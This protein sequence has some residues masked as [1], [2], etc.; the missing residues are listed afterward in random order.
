MG[1]PLNILPPL[2]LTPPKPSPSKENDPALVQELTSTHASLA[3]LRRTHNTTLVQLR[4]AEDSVRTLN[5]QKQKLQT[6]LRSLADRLLQAATAP[7]GAPPP[8]L[9]DDVNDL[10][11]AMTAEQIA[12][13]VAETGIPLSYNEMKHSLADARHEADSARAEAIASQTALVDRDSTI[14][15]LSDQLASMQADLDAAVASSMRVP[16][17]E[18][19]QVHLALVASHEALKDKHA[20]A[21][22]QGKAALAGATSDIDQLSSALH[23][24]KRETAAMEARAL[25]AEE[26]AADAEA[27]VADLRAQLASLQEASESKLDSCHA[28]RL[29]LKAQAEQASD[30]AASRYR[31]LE[32]TY[33]ALVNAHEALKSRYDLLREQMGPLA[34][35]SD[36]H[37]ALQVEYAALKATTAAAMDRIQDL[38]S[39]TQASES[40][41]A[42]YTELA[43]E[44]A[45]VQ[46]VTERA[47]DSI[48]VLQADSERLA[49]LYAAEQERSALAEAQV[50]ALR[51]ELAAAQ[52]GASTA[53]LA[54]A[55]QLVSA[56]Q[57]AS[58]AA[59]RADMA[60]AELHDA[61][62]MLQSMEDE[63]ASLRDDIAELQAELASERASHS[64][65]RT[66]SASLESQLGGAQDALAREERAHADTK[67]VLDRERASRAADKEV[68]AADMGVASVEVTRWREAEVALNAQLKESKISL[69]AARADA[70]SSKGAVAEL[71]ATLSLYESRLEG[72][73]ASEAAL[74]A[75]LHEAQT[76]LRVLRSQVQDSTSAKS[77]L[78]RT[79]EVAQTSLS[80][81]E[82]QIATLTTR[83]NGALET[84]AALEAQIIKLSSSETGWK[85]Q[86]DN[87]E[88]SLR[89]LRSTLASLTS[90]VEE[91]SH[92][93]ELSQLEASQ[94]RNANAHFKDDVAALTTKV[95]ELDHDRQRAEQNILALQMTVKQHVD[96]LAVSE[97]NAGETANALANAKLELGERNSRITQ[98]VQLFKREGY[99][100]AETI[101][102]SDGSSSIRNIVY[103]VESSLESRAKDTQIHLLQ[104]AVADAE[105]RIAD[106]EAQVEDERRN[107]ARAASSAATERDA[108]LAEARHR[109]EDAIAESRE[110]TR[111]K[112]MA[113]Q[114]RLDR[115][116]SAHRE[117]MVTMEERLV[118][119]AEEAS[120]KL[121]AE[122]DAQRTKFTSRLASEA[123]KASARL[124]SVKQ[125][126]ERDLQ[127]ASAK[128][129]S[130]HDTL[131]TEHERAIAD[132]KSRAAD[133]VREAE[134]RVR[135][136]LEHELKSVSADLAHTRTELASIQSHHELQMTTKL[137]ELRSSYEKAAMEAEL[138]AKS[139]IAQL[140]AAASKIRAE[141]E[142]LEGLRSKLEILSSEKV[143]L[144]RACGDLQHENKRIA[145]LYHDKIQDLS[146]R[147]ADL[148]SELEAASEA[149]QELTMA[150]ADARA[151]AD[152]GAVAQAALQDTNARLSAEL[153]SVKSILDA[154]DKEHAATL[155]TLTSAKK[156]IRRLKKANEASAAL[157]ADFEA[158]VKTNA[159]LEEALTKSRA[160]EA[161]TSASLADAQ[162][163]ISALQAGAAVF[164]DERTSL[165]LAIKALEHQAKLDAASA[166][167]A[168]ELSAREIASLKSTL[169][170]ERDRADRLQT[171]LTKAERDISELRHNAK[172]TSIEIS[173]LRQELMEAQSK[174]ARA[175]DTME[176]AKE[177]HYTLLA[178]VEQASHLEAQVSRLRGALEAARSENASLQ[179]NMSLIDDA[180]AQ[181]EA[182]LAAEAEHSASMARA[183]DE[184]CGALRASE[185]QYAELQ[186][187][188]DGLIEGRITELEEVTAERD[189]LAS[190]VAHLEEANAV[191]LAR[192][193]ALDAARKGMSSDQM[194]VLSQLEEMALKYEAAK[195]KG[196]ALS[197]TVEKLEIQNE[198]DGR[199][200][201]QLM[202]Q[203]AELTQRIESESAAR[204][205]ADAQV[206]SQRSKLELLGSVTNEA[207]IE[208]C[209]LRT[210]HASAT[211]QV[212][213][214]QARV[215]Q[216]EEDVRQAKAEAELAK[217][218]GGAGV[219]PESV[220]LARALA[221]AADDAVAQAREQ[222]SSASTGPT[223][224]ATT[225][226]TRTGGDGSCALQE[227]ENERLRSAL[228]SSQA[229]ATRLREENR[230]YLASYS[231]LE[232]SLEGLNAQL[233]TM[234]HHHGSAP[235]TDDGA[236]V[237]EQA[238]QLEVSALQKQNA[239]LRSTNEWLESA[240]AQLESSLLSP[241]ATG[242]SPSSPVRKPSPVSRSGGGGSIGMDAHTK[243]LYAQMNALAQE[244]MGLEAKLAMVRGELAKTEQDL[245][246]ARSTLAQVPPGFAQRDPDLSIPKMVQAKAELESQVERSRVRIEALEAELASSRSECRAVEIEL[247]TVRRA[248][249]AASAEASEARRASA[250]NT[251]TP[252]QLDAQLESIEARVIALAH[253]NLGGGDTGVGDAANNNFGGT[254]DG[255][256]GAPLPPM[257]SPTSQFGTLSSGSGGS[258]RRAFPST[259]SGRSSF[260]VRSPGAV[261]DT[262]VLKLHTDV[263]DAISSTE[264]KLTELATRV[265]LVGIPGLPEVENRMAGIWETC[266]HLRREASTVLSQLHGMQGVLIRRERVLADLAG[267]ESE[268]DEL[269]GAYGQA[270]PPLEALESGS[271]E[272]A[273]QSLVLKLEHQLEM[274]A[275]IEH[276][277]NAQVKQATTVL[278]VLEV[279]AAMMTVSESKARA[280]NEKLAL[281]KEQA[282]P[283]TQDRQVLASFDE[284]NSEYK[285]A[286]VETASRV[287]HLFE[288]AQ[289]QVEALAARM[290]EL[291]V[292]FGGRRAEKVAG[293]PK[294]VIAD[295][296]EDLAGLLGGTTSTTPED[297]GDTDSETA[298]LMS[299]SSPTG[300]NS[301]RLSPEELQALLEAETP[302][303]A[304]DGVQ[305]QLDRLASMISQVS[306]VASGVS[307]DVVHMLQ[308]MAAVV[309]DAVQVLTRTKDLVAVRETEHATQ[310][311]AYEAEL[312]VFSDKI[313]SFMQKFNGQ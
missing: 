51:D 276:H 215:S 223:P 229:M 42:A 14:A 77:A 198:N 285:A 111:A 212:S 99:N 1:T 238:R 222:R 31:D 54:S 180:L 192:A 185:S 225:S 13:D 37:S 240:Y 8:S 34:S 228:L 86:L 234:Q 81:H 33:Y 166:G 97:S 136:E 63:M 281:L 188:Y 143:A 2:N 79:H 290:H 40:V 131:V 264:T 239:L 165:Q 57:S 189:Q 262:Q 203:V 145:S 35:L 88:S 110:G 243:D 115:M 204:T 94:L 160:A 286:I 95:G 146:S 224:N 297:E 235:S 135:R 245:G 140:E 75:Q 280:V 246:V 218:T 163:S 252:S 20:Q 293:R 175:T 58:S 28:S 80:S 90:R 310:I 277:C 121:D 118:D 44:H 55:A 149:L 123:A 186:V 164:D 174:T 105:K 84:N 172:R 199:V 200:K 50:S 24:A 237:Y 64:A 158:A 153:D 48:G 256:N 295:S 108:A 214:L 173:D 46:S 250:A 19:T 210:S 179:V 155:Q 177:K 117:A 87:K 91:S 61:R 11:D 213:K 201:D 309:A 141:E 101:A 137:A 311:R 151:K 202:V 142:E 132:L 116:A 15:A 307:P 25:A 273:K 178:Q 296:P 216:L 183:R 275:N 89:E 217:A 270:V 10:L 41:Q 152:A 36:D 43:A 119:A 197:Q 302:E 299:S 306:L 220:V 147:N 167:E 187:A 312:E 104:S 62:A 73:R 241:A 59:E 148:T 291:A 232:A 289:P 154:L 76:E 195:A 196:D 268:M 171:D 251:L 287:A 18:L 184:L 98:L 194:A 278:A 103:T 274:L 23:D 93:L 279:Q 12:A 102:S 22:N 96:A 106:L 226:T 170:N 69:D 190:K 67:A 74:Q 206:A 182:K 107:A 253:T 27:A 233:H 221:Q 247:D 211:S 298:S 138:E 248:A 176:M 294:I 100:V 292:G 301:M 122:L 303:V 272:A 9:P 133:D 32:Q 308:K 70:A 260:A 124:D 83:L 150:T 21:Q 271:S 128:A 230:Q 269:V 60:F 39:R 257:V 125:K 261:F 265:R 259:G 45:H 305:M 56:E 219:E 254:D 92:A 162:S 82:R 68:Y 49:A 129:A 85:S 71:K 159:Q 17:D 258:G 4:K 130:E 112:D 288:R 266:D 156:K 113:Y 283:D 38:S 53:S 3:Q 5:A 300:A 208:L 267:L 227:E 29:E 157:L 6:G 30:L 144:E 263:I 52:A 169:A 304:L 284:S 231:A 249:A 127:A 65:A 193:S 139:R 168:S 205:A 120:L 244:N 78:E 209:K 26:D 72:A 114:A 242:P 47:L 134:S 207:D 7:P 126:A 66:A 313:V 236:R 109:A 181:T 191:N 255:N 161:E 16:Y 282:S